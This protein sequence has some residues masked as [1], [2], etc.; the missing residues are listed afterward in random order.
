MQEFSVPMVPNAS[1]LITTSGS[2]FQVKYLALL[3]NEEDGGKQEII[4]NFG[5]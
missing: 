4:P 5:H 3:H 2:V 1:F